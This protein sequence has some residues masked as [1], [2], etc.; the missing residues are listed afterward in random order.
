MKDCLRIGL[1]QNKSSLI[2]LRYARYPELKR[3]DITSAYTNK[4]I[5]RCDERGRGEEGGNPVKKEQTAQ[6]I[7]RAD[8]NQLSTSSGEE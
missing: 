1:E 4:A 6:V 8:G 2:S 7:L 5:S 3:Y